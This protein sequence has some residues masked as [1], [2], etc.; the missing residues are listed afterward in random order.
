[1]NRL[2][3]IVHR[4]KGYPTWILSFAVG[5]VVKL[6]G[7]TG[8]SFDLMTKEK[9]IISLKNKTK[10]Q[11]HIGQIHAAAMILLA[12]T[13]TGMVVGMNVP[14]DRLPLIKSIESKFVKRSQG[15][16][17]AVATLNVAQRQLILREEKGEVVVPVKVT[18]ETGDEPIICEMVWAW[19]PKKRKQ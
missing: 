17:Q 12:E 4:F 16:M 10:V 18:D 7:T 9:V 13:A 15:K 2:E 6:V 1:M 19:V 11:N 3:K 8:C 14:D 5:K